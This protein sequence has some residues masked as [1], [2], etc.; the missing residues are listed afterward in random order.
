M[1][2]KKIIPVI[3]VILVAAVVVIST[4][5]FTSVTAERSAVITVA[6][7]SEAL[8]S[9]VPTET[10]NG[11]YLKEGS[12]GAV[13]LDFADVAAEGVNVNAVTV[14]NDVFIITNN[15]TQSVQVILTKTGDNANK[16]LFGDIES[17]VTIGVGG[18]YTV[19][20]EINSYGLSKEN[21]ILKTITLTAT[22][23]ET[24]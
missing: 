5:A 21:N 16:I 19:S 11:K 22:A 24:A 23:T 12:D 20:F 7:D 4:G 10:A 9:I 17:G 6:G 1:D 15:G 14:V 18:T 3:V 2:M 8:L 13:Y